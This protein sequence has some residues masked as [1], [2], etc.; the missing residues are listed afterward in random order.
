MRYATLWDGLAKGSTHQG[1]AG[2]NRRSLEGHFEADTRCTAASWRP[3][4]AASA[5]WQMPR[6]WRKAVAGGELGQIVRP[7]N[8]GWLLRAGRTLSTAFYSADDRDSGAGCGRFAHLRGVAAASADNAWRRR[9]CWG[10]A[11]CIVA[12]ARKPLPRWPMGRKRLLRW[13]RLSD[14][15]Q[16]CYRSEEAGELRLRH[17]HAGRTDRSGALQR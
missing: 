14:R 4:S 8:V 7:L 9:R 1:S 6:E 10:L 17:R 16:V 11:R 3:T 15:E 13:T 12:A 2:R 5:E